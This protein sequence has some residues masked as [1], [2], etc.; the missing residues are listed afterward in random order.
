MKTKELRGLKY[1]CFVSPGSDDVTVGSSHLLAAD[2][3]IGGKDALTDGLMSDYCLR[4][5]V[6]FD[7]RQIF[8]YDY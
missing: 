1:C 5:Y 3:L 6:A 8:F 2:W 4:S 7:I